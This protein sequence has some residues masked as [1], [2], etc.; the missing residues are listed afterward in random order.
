MLNDLLTF[1]A[2]DPAG[3][4]SVGVALFLAGVGIFWRWTSP[5]VFA[6]WRGVRAA[7]RFVLSLRITTKD[8]IIQPATVRLPVARWFVR[9]KPDGR[10]W[11]YILGDTSPG[12][13]ARD[14]V[15]EVHD[16]RMRLMDGA[17]WPEIPGEHAAPFAM[18]GDRYNFFTGVYFSVRWTDEAGKRQRD[19]WEERSD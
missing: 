11:E 10:E 19:D 4:A 14:V 5:V 12:S 16:D 8:K 6:V 15:L 9:P 1:L 17:Q 18:R 7:V 13:V 2:E 3:W